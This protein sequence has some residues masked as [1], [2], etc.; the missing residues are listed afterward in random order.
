MGSAANENGYAEQPTFFS[1]PH[2]VE[3]FAGLK[4][5][6]LRFSS[7]D[8]EYLTERRYA[9]GTELHTELPCG[10]RIHTDQRASRASCTCAAEAR[11]HER[12]IRNLVRSED[13][14][15]LSAMEE[16]LNPE[17][18]KRDRHKEEN[19]YHD[20]R[21]RSPFVTLCRFR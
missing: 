4:P 11:E 2:R 1:Q 9:C 13:Y 19:A 17:Y 10:Q 8:T 21:N 5:I 18:D 16:L 20:Q 14:L 7:E 3:R 15:H 12:S 6:A